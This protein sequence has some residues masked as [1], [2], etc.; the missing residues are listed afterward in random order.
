MATVCRADWT[1]PSEYPDP[2]SAAPTRWAWEFLRR[3]RDYEADWKRYALA[4]RTVANRFPELSAYV[5]C[6]I[7][8]TVASWDRLREPFQS[9]G[10]FSESLNKWASLLR[11]EDEYWTFDPPKLDGESKSEYLSRVQKSSHEP[12]SR[13]LGAKWGLDF[14]A[15]PTNAVS[16]PMR[17]RFKDRM[18]LGTRVPNLDFRAYKPRMSREGWLQHCEDTVE[19]LGKEYPRDLDGSTPA[20]VVLSFDLRYPIAP[21]IESAKEHLE[22]IQSDAKKS[23]ELEPLRAHKWQSGDWVNY[24]RALDAQASS[25]NV[26]DIVAELLPH[27]TNAVSTSYAPR[28]KVDQW[29]KAATALVESGYRKIALIT[30]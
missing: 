5:E 29:L 9:E 27:E 14:I 10:D 23:G 18:H 21:Q 13:W 4:N 24:L 8:D 20:K 6:L 12:L 3:N 28:K 7:A 11:A 22:M 2:A 1:Q 30:L 15:P 17:V 26:N 25:V 19:R 16:S